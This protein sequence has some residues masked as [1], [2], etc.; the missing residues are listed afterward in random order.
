MQ[1]P[2]F[3][4]DKIDLRRK[5]DPDKSRVNILTK[6]YMPGIKYTTASHNPGG[7]VGAVEFVK[8]RIEA[9][10]PKAELK[11]LDT[12]LM[13]LLGQPIAWTFASSFRKLPE[14]KWVS[15]RGE[16]HG[17]LTEWEP[18]EMSAEDL[19]GCNLVW[20]EV[21]RLEVTLDGKEL[22]YWDWWEGELRPD[23]N[24]SLSRRALGI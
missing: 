16:I 4:N 17:A 2:L 18:D 23:P 6:L 12:D 21:T 3:I 14:N 24:A 15:C 8:P 20:K 1:Q 10:E 7:G 11:G 13:G 5:D 19:M 22:L 9:P